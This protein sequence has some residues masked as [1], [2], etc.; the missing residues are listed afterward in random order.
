MADA[1]YKTYS[2]KLQNR[3]LVARYASDE[4]PPG[5]YR[6]L[7]NLESRA[8]GSLATRYGLQALTQNGSVDQPLGAPVH[9]LGKI[10]SLGPMYRYAGAGTSLYRSPAATSFAP[11]ATGMSGARLSM[12]PYRPAANANPWMFI[13][14]KNGLL[15]DSGSGGAQKWGLAPPLQ[16]PSVQIGDPS[17]TDIELFGEATTASFALSAY[18]AASLPVRFQ[19]TL[20]ATGSAL[21]IVTFTEVQPVLSSI[22]RAASVATVTTVAAHGWVSGMRISVAF[23][24]D[25]SFNVSSVIITVTGATTFTYPNT[26]ANVGPLSGG[27]S[28]LSALP[29]LQPYSRISID[30]AGNQ[31]A[32]TIL[33]I[34]PGIGFTAYQSKPHTGSMPY[35]NT[36]L[37]GS[38]AANT[39]ATI[40]KPGNFDFTGTSAAPNNVPIA[41]VSS[42]RTA[43]V[44]TLNLG[45]LAPAPSWKPG[46]VI[47]VALGSS[48]DFNTSMSP[49]SGLAIDGGGNFLVSYQQLGLPNETGG[50]GTVQKTKGNS[51][52]AEDDD[53]F[54]LFLLVSNP[55]SVAEIRLIFDVGDGTFTKD[56]FYKSITPSTAQP[57]IS[58]SL[59]NSSV[60]TQQ[61]FA[62]ASGL[63]DNRRLGFQSEDL[64]PVDLQTLR[65]LRPANLNTG[66]SAWTNVQMMRG[67]FIAVGAAGGPTNGWDKVVGWRISIHTQPNSSVTVGIDDLMFVAGSQIDAFNG[68]PYDYRITFYNINTGLESNPSI[69]LDESLFVSPRRQPLLVALNQVTHV[70]DVA[71]IAA[72]VGALSADWTNP[73]NFIGSVGYAVTSVGGVGIPSVSDQLT[74]T[75][76]GFA[77]PPG[78]NLSTALI[79]FKYFWTQIGT[80][81][82]SIF[83]QPVKNGVLIGSAQVIPLSATG[84][85]GGSAGSPLS[86]QLTF[87]LSGLSVADVNDPTFGFEITVLRSFGGTG[88]V[89]VSANAATVTLFVG[90][91]IDQQVTHWRIYRRGGTLTQS[92]FLVDQVPIT[93]TTYLDIISD[94][95]IE[96]NS[97]LVIDNDPP[98]SSTMPV[99]LNDPIAS[100]TQPSIPGLATISFADFPTSVFAGQFVTIGSGDTSEDA[101]VQIVQNNG[102][103]IQLWLQTAHNVGE[104]ISATEQPQAPVSLMAIA[105]DKAWLAGDANNPHVL[106]YSNPFSPETFPQE[107]F[108]EVGTPDAPIMALV[109]HRGL[110]YVFTTKTIFQILGAGSSVPITIPTGVKHGLTGS[111]AWAR[112]EGVIY[113]ESYDGIYA[114]TGSTSNYVTEP[115]EWIFTSKNLGPVPS[116]GSGQK[117]NTV[118]AYGNHELFVSYVD[119]T[120]KRRRM[121]FSDT[122][123]RWR[124]DDSAKT[125][126]N[127]M[128]FEDDTGTFVVGGI[129]GMVYQDRQNDYDWGELADGLLTKAPINFMLQSSQMDQDVAKAD[130][131]YQEF[132]LD[133]NLNGQQV[134]VSLIFDDGNTIKPLG[135]LTGTGRQQYQVNIEKGLGYDSLNVG[136][137]ITGSVTSVVILHEVHIRA[138]VMAE[139]R[140]C[141]DTYKM[142]CGTSEF[143]FAKQGWFIYQ[144]MADV[145]VLMYQ[146][147]NPMPLFKF[148]LPATPLRRTTRVRLPATKFNV[149]RFIGTSLD[150]FQMYPETFL[151]MKPISAGK[152]YSRTPIFQ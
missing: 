60:L 19:G 118:M 1:Q 46:D 104:I 110:L 151:E 44:S 15:K 39:T 10:Q 43:G 14:D 26:G 86:T 55:F 20:A 134:S 88:N 16:P 111:F 92:W 48:P 22:Q 142:D 50:A 131:H 23:S 37:T 83:V 129:D 79:N 5:T 36:Y 59:P 117:A 27:T 97:E 126:I 11:I 108:I 106:Y 95:T 31:E 121:I 105:F 74:A 70:T 107:N 85:S 124:N 67:E 80:G 127:A 76:F 40:S 17:K 78:S 128:N 30:T 148:T 81:I 71:G 64:L 2:Y 96:I 51:T 139:A 137:L 112:A 140:R 29:S 32:I 125:D 123:S 132:T 47:A 73:N 6:N 136:V 45:V 114:F 144:A 56:Y 28:S 99:P 33:T 91:P 75:Q 101:Y 54:S 4:F 38:V 113:Y 9:S 77:V 102:G 116:E 62:R 35:A 120:G 69:T 52:V 57:A 122:Y 152:G 98:V 68:N 145:A 90:S 12:A 109:E 58:A 87:D 138:L 103:T 94:A 133:A 72:S 150:D 141:W 13:A 42:S 130:K 7:E 146:D 63:T 135:T 21:G 3:G 100:I 93:T 61:V 119:A 41:V 115:V 82:F 49:I 34:V 18:T 65:Q 8:E 89:Q 143:K 53:F 25:T 147:D 149:I 84:T 66:S 24:P